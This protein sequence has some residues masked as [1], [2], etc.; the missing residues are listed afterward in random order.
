MTSKN[1]KGF[2]LVEVVV[3]VAILLLLLS[4]ILVE[5]YQTLRINALSKE[6]LQALENANSVLETFKAVDNSKLE[7]GSGTIF[8]STSTTSKGTVTCSLYK[9]D[10]TLIGTVKYNYTDYTLD[11]KTFGRHSYTR[12]ATID[13]L[14][15]KIKTGLGGKEYNIIYDAEGA[16]SV[17]GTVMNN[18][19]LT[20]TNEGSYVHYDANNHVDRIVVKEDTDTVTYNDPNAVDLGRIQD[21]DESKVVLIEGT[22]SNYDIQAEE[23]FYNLKMQT[24]KK[25]NPDQYDEAIKS[26]TGK[27]VFNTVDFTETVHKLTM[28]TITDKDESGAKLQSPT[29]KTMYRVYCDV[30]YEDSYSLPK[31]G[32]GRHSETKDVKY[33]VYSRDF[34]T[35][36]CP[37]IYL[38]YEPFVYNSSSS[39]V[40]YAATDYIAVD[41]RYTFTDT[42]PAPLMYLIEPDE[43]K[44][45][46]VNGYTSTSFMNYMA[47]NNL[48]TVQPDYQKIF[49]T[50]IGGAADAYKPVVLDIFKAGSSGASDIDIYT[51]IPFERGTSSTGETVQIIN[52]A[53]A[54]AS[55]NA[56]T[57]GSNYDDATDPD[58]HPEN[59][60]IHPLSDNIRTGDGSLFTCTVTYQ[61]LDNSGAVVSGYDVRFQSGKGAE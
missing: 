9:A 2:S 34:I 59:I 61:M 29:G 33:R 31:K 7:S 47:A 58:N 12:R 40:Q 32:G 54:S 3:S 37:D 23:D 18:L 22:A 5:F 42:D 19:Q 43:T 48:E 49:Y 38:M 1:N 53:D 50:N 11:G 16:A 35:N 14:S 57:S 21:L 45:D 41:N 17:S 44:F 24:L 25:V 8:D 39:S 28:L 13:D 52:N 55:F 10:Q 30:I 4:P 60:H 6:R 46:S 20:R 51:N 15:N 27:T 36:R 26:D 56:V